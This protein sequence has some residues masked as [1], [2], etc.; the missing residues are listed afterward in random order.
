MSTRLILASASPR[1]RQLLSMLDYEFEVVASRSDESLPPETGPAEAARLLARRKAR[2]VADLY[3]D[4]VVVGADTMVVCGD[5]ILGKPADEADAARM[6][7]ML[8]GRSHRVLTGLCVLGGGRE[9]TA[10]EETG[11]YF[12]PLTAEAVAAYVATGEPLDK[13]GAYAIQGGAGKF[14]RRIE[15]CYYNVGG[16]PLATLD[17]MLT[18]AG[19][20]RG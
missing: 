8:S 9:Q 18:A 1:R 10:V 4:A 19:C 13:A 5:R 17:R 16:L 3:P 14:V 11:V 6:L 12:I 20:R 7:S 15:G 2:A